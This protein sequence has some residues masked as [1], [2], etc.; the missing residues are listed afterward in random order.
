MID[1]SHRFKSDEPFNGIPAE[2]LN[3]WQDAA[4]WAARRRLT[5]KQNTLQLQ[6]DNVLYIKN[7]SGGDLDQFSI[8]RRGD[9]L[10]GPDGAE[11][12]FFGAACFE[13]ESPLAASP[14]AI[15][16]EPC[17]DGRL[18]PATISG[19]SWCKVNL[20]DAAHKF[21]N[22]VD[23]DYEK[24]TSGTSGRAEIFW[25]DVPAA[26]QLNG[27]ID[28]AVTTIYVDTGT[29]WPDPPF[30]ITIEDEELNVTAIDYPATQLNG[31]IND[32]VT[33]I[34]VDSSAGFPPTPFVAIIESERINVTNVAGT[35]WTVEREYQGTTR[36]AHA[37]NAGVTGFDLNVWTVERE[38]NDTEAAE[39]ADDTAVTFASGVVWAK[40][41]LNGLGPFVPICLT[42]CNAG[43][44]CLRV[45]QSWVV[46]CEEGIS[47]C[48]DCEIPETLCVTFNNYENCECWS[49]FQVYLTRGSNP[50]YP[51]RYYGEFVNP[52]TGGSWSIMFGCNWGNPNGD[53]GLK[54]VLSWLGGGAAVGAS[55]GLNELPYL[56]QMDFNNCDP[57]NAVATVGTGGFGLT[58]P[59]IALALCD[60]TVVDPDADLVF[61]TMTI[62][63]GPCTDDPVVNFEDE[64]IC[65]DEATVEITGLN[66]NL[67]P[68][69]NT[70]TLNLGATA[71]VTAVGGGGTTATLTFGT[72]P[73]T[74]VL[75][76]ILDNGTEDSG[77]AV[78]IATVI[79]CSAENTGNIEYVTPGLFALTFPGLD[80]T[81]LTFFT[82]GAGGDGHT[83]HA[84]GGGG[85]GYAQVTVTANHGDHFSGSV[86]VGGS[87]CGDSTNVFDD[88]TATM[89]AQA[90]SGCNGAT[91]GSGGLGLVGDI[92]FT[93]GAGFADGSATD[94]AGGGGAAGPA[95][96]GG[97]AINDL[98][99][100]SGDE[101]DLGGNGGNGGQNGQNYGG[102]GGA[103]ALGAG[104]Q[105]LVSWQPDYGTPH[106][107]DDFT[108]ADATNL[109][110]HTPTGTG[111]GYSK[112]SGA[113]MVIT[114]NQLIATADSVYILNS[115]SGVN[116]TT[117]LKLTA[118]TV[119]GDV[120]FVGIV[121]RFTG[122]GGQY[123][124]VACGLVRISGDWGVIVNDGANNLILPVTI[125]EDTEYTLIVRDYGPIVS[126]EVNGV[127]VQMGTTLH[128]G[129]AARTLNVD[130]AGTE[131]A[132]DDLE[133]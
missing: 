55:E 128:A 130:T 97:T 113:N 77:D 101:G 86:S 111:A 104:G 15:L 59:E 108:D 123:G 36:V 78:Q 73:S 57:F 45:P 89:I 12:F 26:T 85:G 24:L 13:S 132:F 114:G 44:I 71:T 56:F 42:D 43:T 99:A 98:G 119:S 116:T 58:S 65:T 90:V 40:V 133:V 38:F 110:D 81:P 127:L 105:V 70:V 41:L 32:S 47:S 102:G 121:L 129:T 23:G 125:D 11:T 29:N 115:I 93:G 83:T 9:K 103:L 21:A 53:W 31:G 69:S 88:A 61:L 82:R 68:G 120:A 30:V 117:T 49:G 46:P 4:D 25:A 62:I 112:S 18:A 28:D 74:G 87:N 95:F 27:A 34:T 94:D 2:V 6:P 8:V 33:T 52:C 16:Q 60:Y 48:E 109:Q 20:T 39:H 50:L 118:T 96:D 67:T 1:N 66:F 37:D 63:E 80:G 106:W 35:T 131:F 84:F 22:V 76:C 5:D 54:V 107:S 91:G 10:V 72:P 17:A 79:D 124:G 75:T 51:D 19:H 92:K 14:F 7:R 3:R 126:A 64:D 100:D 122:S